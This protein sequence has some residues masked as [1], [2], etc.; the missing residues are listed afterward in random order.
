M[1]KC[2][3]FLF[4]LL[5][6]FSFCEFG[7]CYSFFTS[8]WLFSTISSK[9]PFDAFVDFI[10]SKP[11]DDG[12]SYLISI[13]IASTLFGPTSLKLLQWKE[14]HILADLFG[15]TLPATKDWLQIKPNRIPTWFIEK[16]FDWKDM[17]LIWTMV[18]A[19]MN[20]LYLQMVSNSVQHSHRIINKINSSGSF[21][22]LR[23]AHFS[24]YVLIFNPFGLQLYT[25]QFF[26]LYLSSSKKL[27]DCFVISI[28][29]VFEL[30]LTL[31]L[32]SNF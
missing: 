14:P 32:I 18:M 28:Q 13:C 5:L 12:D 15:R 27:A 23:N 29:K 6:W 8:G 11:N 9:G 31:R 3:L 20:C 22:I 26:K 2:C 19:A 21:L 10:V 17:M 30:I 1:A 25:N 7:C 24:F 16:Y 4:F